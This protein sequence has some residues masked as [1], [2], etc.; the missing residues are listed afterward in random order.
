[1]N[2]AQ[3]QQLKN[4]LGE[5]NVTR[6]ESKILEHT[7]SLF[8]SEMDAKPEVICYPKNK[9]DILKIVNFCIKNRI[10]IIPYGAG[11]SVEGHVL[12]VN[13]GICLNMSKLKRILEI[14]VD[15]EYVVVEPGLKY[16]EL[17]EALRASGLYF[18]VEAAWDA[19]LGGMVSTNASGAGAYKH[20][21]MRDN[22]KGCEV[23]TYKEGRAYSF[24]AG[25]KTTKSSAG[26]DIKSIFA[27]A[28]GTLGIIT[29]LTLKV[30]RLPAAQLTLCCQ[31]TTI[32]EITPIVISLRKNL[33]SL[34]LLELLG[35][36]QT[37]ACKNY[38]GIN[39]LE[40]NKYTLIIKLSGNQKII[41]VDREF[42]DEFFLNKTPS[43]FFYA[44]PDE[45]INLWAMR[46]QACP[47]AINWYGADKKAIATD[48]CVPISRFS[49]YI[50]QCEAL[51]DQLAL[52]APLVSHAG[53][54]NIHFTILINPDLPFEVEKAKKFHTEIVNLAIELG[55]S[56]TGEHGI[57]F[58]KK[59][60]LML[61]HPT[62]TDEFL[63]IKKTF[64]PLNIFNPGKIV[65][66]SCG[67]INDS[68]I[69][70]FSSKNSKN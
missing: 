9:E 53:D 70:L 59:E 55:G 30:V 43:L 29:E 49:D 69:G 34:D 50:N 27:G 51:R 36:D 47:A 26:Y 52:T 33:F 46:K 65:I 15:D 62:L 39:Q 38:S 54:A 12:A 4:L 42:I 25:N 17:N 37:T 41:N 8:F 63:K 20:R 35:K 7:G 21:N 23:V 45:E 61:E 56:C 58:G 68:Q 10:P 19:T 28:E 44:N 5:E 48:T 64:D 3:I 57:G 2:E 18:P 67:Y 66:Y 14:A 22:L 32:E 60:F 13:G 31:F 40:D 16:R 24:R 1:M 11:T 6:D